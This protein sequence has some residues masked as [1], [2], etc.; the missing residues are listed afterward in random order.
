[1][2]AYQA[3]WEDLLSLTG[4]DHAPW[5]VVPADRKWYRNLVISK[6]LIDTLAGLDMAYP[7]PSKD[8]AQISID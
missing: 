2:N 7:E 6:V 3:A 1:M 5:Y 8:L 4:T